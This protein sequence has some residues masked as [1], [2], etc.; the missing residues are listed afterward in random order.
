MRRLPEESQAGPRRR[1]SASAVVLGCL[2]LGTLLTL[3]VYN[4]ELHQVRS[5]AHDRFL[6]EVEH[7]KGGLQV[8]FE[9][10]EN[11]VRGAVGLFVASR[12]VEPET[13]QRYLRAMDFE[14]T[15]PGMEGMWILP[16]PPPGAPPPWLEARDML[17]E[18]RDTGQGRLVSGM[19]APKAGSDVGDVTLCVPVYRNGVPA[20][21]VDQ[22]RG[23]FL[24]WV[25]APV[26][27][28]ALTQSLAR[29]DSTYLN[30][31]ILEP[32]GPDLWKV[33]YD[34]GEGD[35]H[36]GLAQAQYQ[37]E[38]SVRLW[39]QKWRVRF[40]SLPPFEIATRSEGPKIILLLGI[41][42]SCLSALLVWSLAATRSRAL[43]LAEEMTF[44]LRLAQEEQRKLVALSENS[45]DSIGIATLDA[46]YHYLNAAGRKM[47]GF[48]P[49]EDLKGRG[50]FD[51]MPEETQALLRD[52]MLPVV[53]S[54]GHWEGEGEVAD[55]STGTPL[56]VQ[57]TAFPVQH[58][59]SN[60][61]AYLAVV[62]R[63]VSS[64]KRAQKALANSLGLLEATIE[65]TED[66]ILVVDR[67]GNVTRLNRRFLDMWRIPEELA[68]CGDDRRLLNHVVNQLKDPEEFL[69]GVE[70]LYKHPERESQD[71]VEFTDGRVYERYSRP[72]R[73]GAELTGRV[74]SFHDISERKRGEEALRSAEVRFR[75][76][77]EQ[78]LVG[79]YIIRGERFLY[80]NPKMAEITGYGQ[81]ELLTMHSILDCVVEEDRVLLR[82]YLHSRD[83]AGSETSRNRY[84][85]RW[86]RKDGV[87]VEAE[88]FRSATEF[89][90]QPTIFGVMLD[91][92]EQRRMERD[93]RETK[94]AA[95]AASRA[96][97]E[98]LANTSHE[99]RTPMNGILGMIDVLMDS[100]LGSEQRE[101]AAVIR[102]SAET[103]LAIVNDI[104]DLSK[105]ESGM[106]V[107]EIVDFSLRSI[108]E[109]SVELF[110]V[111]AHQKGLELNCDYPPDSPEHLRGDPGRIRQVI[112]NLVGNAVKFTEKGEIALSVRISAEMDREVRVHLTVADTGIGIPI[113]RQAAIFDSFTQ[114]DGSTTR[115]YGGTGLGLTISRHIVEKMG[116]RIRLTSAPGVGSS[117]LVEFWLPRQ[118][119]HPVARV[120]G[121]G[122]EGRKRL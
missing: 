24:G 105:I 99:I 118:D 57:I 10:Y 88:D 8:A 38:D 109:E 21:T 22:R 90:G 31:Q 91:V 5:K 63:D 83:A 58:T 11:A 71:L 20:S 59:D 78:S 72:Q 95:E 115:R 49:D 117:F 1:L 80:V 33:L 16:A 73:I 110:A 111:A 102:D 106:M 69:K 112:S 86:R 101:Y 44:E 45:S 36:G 85:L 37:A 67:N 12:E 56:I 40:S 107:L 13:W 41:L 119:K 84:H 52:K 54:G 14:H 19:L 61:P 108:V 26:R 97:S 42:V 34:S 114:A 47:A 122:R 93:L 96:K 92:T 2:A 121:D 100:P 48:S 46:R 79:I 116:G 75:N 64:G 113:E 51:A 77:V 76:L 50:I 9:N 82:R 103:L 120:A 104:L 35:R 25:A 65:S 87:I 68:S 89:E 81:D 98:F 27:V 29:S 66:G 32:A 17:E 23:A 74:W 55:A 28:P 53:R 3:L 18:V 94:E 7:A 6:F 39:N 60:E 62:L 4:L 15:C 30:V 70:E 43:A